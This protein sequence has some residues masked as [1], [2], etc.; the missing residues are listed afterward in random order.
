MKRGEVVMVDWNYSDR[1]GSKV[2]PAI[3]V[4]SDFLNS[5]IDDTVLIPVT[6]TG[7]AIGVTEVLIDPAVETA[8]G[9]RFVSVVSCNNFITIDQALVA[10]TIGSLSAVMMKKIDACLKLALE[11]P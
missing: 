10:R 8:S 3:V 7:R 5:S 9:L 4:Q 6:K 11:L 2:R 1:T